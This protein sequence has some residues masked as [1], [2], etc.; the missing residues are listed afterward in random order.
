MDIKKSTLMEN[1]K[2]L[3]ICCLIAMAPF[4]YGIDFG[5]ISGIQAMVG[6]LQVFG[7][8]DPA[9]P[10]GYNLTTVTQQLISSLMTVG[11][12]VG[13]VLCGPLGVYISR[14]QGLWL[15]TITCFVSNA[16]MMGT[17]NIKAVYFARLLIGIAN[18]FF[19]VFAQLFLQEAAPPHLR[20]VAL[21][22]YQWWCSVGTLI[23][24]I[25]D[26][27]TAPLAGRQSYLIPL[28]LIYVVPAILSVGIIFIPESPR[29]L[30]QNGKF[31]EARDALVRLRP[32]KEDELHIDEE[33]NEIKT[34]LEI[35]ASLSESASYW[36]M[37][38]NPVDRRRT[39]LSI[40]A[41]SLQGAS[42]ALFMLIYGT[43]FFAMAGEA[44]PFEDSVILTTVGVAIITVAFFYVRLIGRRVILMVGMGVSALAMLIQAIV[45]T[46]APGTV[47]TGKVVVG[48]AVLYII[49]YNGCVSAFAW[50]VGGEI[51]SQ[52][53]RGQTLG[54][55]AGM[56]FFLGWL[57][58]FTAPYFI[59]AASLNWGPKYGYI[60]F[61]TN[62]MGLVWIYL[63]LPETKDRTLE[64]LDE[65]FAA[66]LPARKFAGYV[67]T[68]VRSGGYGLD[69]KNALGE[70]GGVEFVEVHEVG[71]VVS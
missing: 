5:M 20:G 26:N 55:S 47:S 25:V 15:A 7:Y 45:Y 4:Q 59:N 36:D 19:Q 22:L 62:I 30:A 40:G 33:L 52:R 37:W 12:I 16:I 38:K 31:D 50:L 1:K 13:S 64:E 67:C 9:S 68:T 17:S 46:K 28:G 39:L 21:A 18:G 23:G 2:A 61:V 10:L 48:M 65:M 58:A 27:F 6:F 66:R 71:Q 11:A 29:W 43:Y 8:K 34:G 54:I 57:A 3:L 49:F 70:K 44:K 42:G 24:T 14:R 69:E 60:W 53:F 51:P 35:E 63:Y 32:K 56:G 41:V